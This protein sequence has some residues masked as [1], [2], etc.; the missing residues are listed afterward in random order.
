MGKGGTDASG[1]EGGLRRGQRRRPEAPQ[2]F[3]VT[4]Y[5]VLKERFTSY[6]S[7]LFTVVL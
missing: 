7:T 3:C 2:R 1:G 4:S 5:K 6:L